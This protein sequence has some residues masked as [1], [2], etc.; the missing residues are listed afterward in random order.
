MDEIYAR[1]TAAQMLVKEGYTQEQANVI[2]Q[3]AALDTI[4]KAV[5]LGLLG[6]TTATN[7]FGLSPEEVPSA[8]DVFAGQGDAVTQA[9][10]GE[11]PWIDGGDIP[12]EVRLPADGDEEKPDISDEL[13]NITGAIDDYESG[14]LE[15]RGDFKWGPENKRTGEKEL[16]PSGG[17][18]NAVFYGSDLGMNEAEFES[19]LQQL[20]ATVNDSGNAFQSM[21]N[22]IQDQGIQDI[23]NTIQ[24]AD[25]S[26]EQIE[27]LVQQA[28]AQGM[29][30]D[31]VQKIIDNPA[32]AL[33]GMV[34][35]ISSIVGAMQSATTDLYKFLD[36]MNTSGY[37]DWSR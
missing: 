7:V 8:E 25:I 17:P 2:V 31:A 35:D 16:L 26:P 13:D 19:M 1:Y 30:A 20:S 29:S 36:G 24:N 14:G 6:L 12:D 9:D 23:A 4:K 34:D 3:E 28:Q 37:I 27:Q 22:D 21:L 5:A 33:S 11:S 10:D 32:G 15:D 18:E